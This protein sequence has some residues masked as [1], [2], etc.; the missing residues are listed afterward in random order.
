MYKF[1]FKYNSRTFPLS[2]DTLNVLLVFLKVSVVIKITHLSEVKPKAEADTHHSLG[3]ALFQPVSIAQF[4][5]TVQN[6]HALIA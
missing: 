6:K 1:R 2:L 4:D 3:R 5:N